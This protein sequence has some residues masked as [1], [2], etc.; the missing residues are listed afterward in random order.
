MK[1]LADLINTADPAW[2]L[3]QEWLA[4]ATNPVEILPRNPAAA[5]A[6]LLKT[7][8]TT[9]SVMGAVVYETG[10]ILIDH[11]WLRILGSGS[12]KLPRGLGSWNLGRTQSEPA[13]PAPYYLI[14]DDAAG[15]YF[16]LNG[17]GLDGTPGNVFYLPP[18]TLEWEDCEL[19]YT[20]FLNWAFSGDLA[21]FYENVRWAGWQEEA[22]ALGGDSVYHFFPP[23]W[24]EEGADIEQTSRRIIPIA[25]HYDATL[26]ILRQ[27]AE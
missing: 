2:P 11:G 3:I 24:T 25:E 27:L 13:S 15:G 10:G 21:L 20:D 22:A 5:E 18:D 9:R 17:G 7:Q 16:A 19:G 14:A 23:L 8:V 1:T 26:D 4:E 6:E 12:A